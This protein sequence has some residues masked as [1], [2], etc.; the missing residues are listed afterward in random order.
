MQ[1][2]QLELLQQR[3]LLFIAGVDDEHQLGQ[4]LSSCQLLDGHPE[5]QQ[6]P[7]PQRQ[8]LYPVIACSPDSA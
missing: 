3:G 4:G 6:L 7:R 2:V 1:L 5:C 8:P